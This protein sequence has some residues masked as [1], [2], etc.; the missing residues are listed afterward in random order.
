MRN[1]DGTKEC[2]GMHKKFLTL[3]L[4]LTVV[5]LFTVGAF[6]YLID[7]YSIWRGDR[8]PGLNMWAL[9][10][11][12]VERLG[13]AISII[14]A[15]PR[16]EVVFIGSSQVDWGI[17]AE[18][19]S[20]ML[21]RPV[22]NLGILGMTA[23]EQ[24]RY[25]EHVLT[26]DSA[27]KEMVLAVDF[28]KFVSGS[29][30]KT[31]FEEGMADV[32]TQIGKKYVVVDNLE[33]TLF[34]LQALKDSYDSFVDNYRKRWQVPYY[35]G[36]KTLTHE[37][38]MRYF[39]REHWLFNRSLLLVQR[40]GWLENP[41][42]NEKSFQELERIAAL[43]QEHGVKL[44]LYVPPMH[45][46]AAL[47]YCDCMDTYAAWMKRL[48]KIAPIWSFFEFNEISTSPVQDGK[49]SENT[50]RYFWDSVHHKDNVGKWIVARMYGMETADMPKGFGIE[51]TEANLDEY[52]DDMRADM[53]A[54]ELT[55]PEDMEAV[56]YYAGF[57]AIAPILVAGKEKGAEFVPAMLQSGSADAKKVFQ[58]RRTDYLELQGN[59]FLKP[60]SL[61]KSYLKITNSQGQCWYTIAEPVVS[62]EAA[63]FMHNRAYEA[64]GFVVKEPVDDVPVGDYDINW[65][66]LT[67]D[68][69]IFES[70][71][72]GKITI[73]D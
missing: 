54:W 69:R 62:P 23:Y 44:R 25:V 73:T 34:S 9:K 39:D 8:R 59:G 70:E 2:A 42:L 33:K 46:E 50:N 71:S 61:K 1:T 28:T 45:A 4:S 60:G 3:F 65:V 67:Q 6:S 55:H 58:L 7:P 37:A 41:E 15:D 63:H 10:A 30:Y 26:V 12:G 16:P 13:K 19:S 68:N 5:M 53:K 49:F 40:E 14:S 20:K 52:I 11:D 35:K 27:V 31:P 22:Y 72:L 56:R 51:V 17:D 43:C 18:E 64:S 36:G 21:G 57:S 47:S 29:R 66:A 24:R 48:S 32:E 38:L